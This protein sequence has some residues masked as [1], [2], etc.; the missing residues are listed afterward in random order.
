MFSTR[1]YTQ[2]HPANT[3][4]HT[5][6]LRHTVNIFYSR[7]ELRSSASL[8]ASL[9]FP[10]WIEDAR[11]TRQSCRSFMLLFPLLLVSNQFQCLL[12]ARTK[13]SSSN[14]HGSRASQQFAAIR[15]AQVIKDI[16]KFMWLSAQFLFLILSS[17]F[18]LLR[19]SAA[20]AASVLAKLN[21]T[22]KRVSNNNNNGPGNENI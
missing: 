2:I 14:N 1:D 21:F 6:T 3:N 22:K 19:V 4:T 5:R 17:S 7:S 13:S 10:N 12:A 18:F 16:N 9:F 8:P 11:S 15:V 20:A